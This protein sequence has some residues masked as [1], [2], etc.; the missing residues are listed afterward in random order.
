MNGR[1]GV[2]IAVP[3]P[4]VRGER[5]LRALEGLFL[6]LDRWIHAGI[7]EALNPFTQTGA[8]ANSCFVIAIVSGVALLF[9]YDATVHGAYASLE[10]LRNA[11]LTAQLARSIHRYSSDACMFFVLL[12]ALRM[13][14]SRKFG[15]PRWLA[16]VTG[17]ILFV[18]LWLV[19]WLG[20]WLVWDQR[21]QQVAVGTSKLL[22]VLPIFDDPPYRSFL[23]D[24]SINSLL[25]FIVFFAHML[26]PLGMGIALWLHITR[27][28]RSKFFTRWPMTLLVLGTLIALS[29]A[30]PATSAPAA[31]MTVHPNS[32][33]FDAWYLLPL[34]LTDRLGG[35]ALWTLALL[36]TAAI[37]SVPWSLTRGRA[38]V[39]QVNTARCNGCRR[40]HDDCPYQAITMV[41]RTDR[42]NF[43]VQA[44]VDPDKCVGCGIC[45]GACEP[46]AIDLPWLPTLSERKKLDTWIDQC[47]Q[48]S[49]CAP[50]VAFVCAESA[51]AGLHI[52]P[53]HGECEELPGYKV[54]PVPCI[55][56]VNA[57]TV[58]R[59]LRHGAAGVLLVAC[60]PGDCQYREGAQWTSLR[61]EG[62]R[63]P[64]LRHDR[65]NR[66][67][68]RFL[69]LDRLDTAALITHA[70]AFQKGTPLSAQTRNTPRA[71]ATTAMLVFTLGG[72]TVAT[73]DLVYAGPPATGPELIVSFKHPGRTS[74][75]CRTVTSEENARVPPH[76]RRDRICERKRAP[77]RLRVR[78]DGTTVMVK[79]FPPRGIHGDE[80]SVALERIPVSAGPHQ[81]TVEIGDGPDPTEWNYQDQR[82]LSFHTGRRRV[83]LFDR[84]NLFRWE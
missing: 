32:F 29:L 50:H 1:T 4:P 7:P 23:T 41:P 45:S 75:N 15:G 34:T 57:L 64:A 77:V 46:A 27:L 71:L 79:S 44:T 60:S 28:S 19:G 38:A 24:G 11:P 6:H 21:A 14:F 54:L 59:A 72:A 5:I 17:V 10:A 66:H 26:L 36:T 3:E 9:W 18:L 48:D 67:R 8:I 56:W 69:Q 31:R 12:H 37:T 61:I 70:Q 16:W 22:D 73:S 47:I 52:H 62:A 80:A 58:E 2:A 39:A 83:V 76:M 78:I 81:V 25:F 43:E 13:F 30:V 51:A 49:H 68:V 53:T 20:Y 35:G 63:P 55:G 82:T 40:C 84:S 42:R 74:E 65:I 33:R